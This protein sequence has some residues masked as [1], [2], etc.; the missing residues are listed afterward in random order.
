[1]QDHGSWSHHI[2]SSYLLIIQYQHP[3]CPACKMDWGGEMCCGVRSLIWNRLRESWSFLQ[4]EKANDHPDW[5]QCNQAQRFKSQWWYSEVFVPVSWV[6]CT[7]VKAL[8]ILIF[9]CQCDNTCQWY[10]AD[11]KSRRCFDVHLLNIIISILRETLSLLDVVFGLVLVF[12]LGHQNDTSFQRLML[13]SVEHSQQPGF[14]RN[15]AAGIKQSKWGG[16]E[17]WFWKLSWTRPCHP[18]YKWCPW[19]AVMKHSPPLVGKI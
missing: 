16:A 18:Q 3:V 17:I 6:T 12:V 10:L 13:I 2:T 19:C 5:H 14:Q 1:M 15:K 4:A 9:G 11:F 7:S 8:L